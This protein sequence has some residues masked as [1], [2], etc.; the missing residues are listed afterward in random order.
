MF[1]TSPV[2]KIA[3]RGSLLALSHLFCAVFRCLGA[4]RRIIAVIPY[5]WVSRYLESRTRCIYVTN[6][7]GR[8]LKFALS[9]AS[10]ALLFATHHFVFVLN[11]SVM[12]RFTNGGSLIDLRISP[13]GWPI[14][15]MSRA[16]TWRRNVGYGMWNYIIRTMGIRTMSERAK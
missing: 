4:N 2:T 5:S 10:S 14:I 7:T 12:S 1:A 16:F 9:I 15:I 8:S 13:F 6:S 11:L 3:N